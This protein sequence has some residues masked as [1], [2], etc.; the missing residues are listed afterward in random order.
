M[1]KKKNIFVSIAIIVVLIL[2]VSAASYAYLLFS[3][4]GTSAKAGS[5]KLDINYVKF[6]DITGNL[7]A[8]SDR[9][10]GL[11]AS[12]S[13]SLNTGSMG[14]L[15]N[16]YITPTVLTNLNIPA[17]KWEAEGVREGIVVCSNSGNFSSAV[18]GNK[19]KIIDG[20]E[21]SSTVTTF[22]VYIWL[23]ASLINTSIS[24]VNF[25]AKISV[26]SAP[27]TGEF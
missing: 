21:L 18:V 26:D 1:N 24:G 22:N 5:G 15:F 6:S 2:L 16:I 3:T 20:C 8:S 4:S 13:A 9:N 19:I 14:A 17:L 27:I 7:D 25:G 11:K 12:A 23:D 10:N